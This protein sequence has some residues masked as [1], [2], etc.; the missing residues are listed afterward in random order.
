[1]HIV[2]NWMEEGIEQGRRQGF[3]LGINRGIEREKKLIVHLIKKKLGT[4]DAE[5][6]TQIISLNL[7]VVERLAE[8]TFD[9][10]TVED[11]RN[12]LDNL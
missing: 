3:E 8:A 7:N 2:T 12:W 1:M 11:L 4:I 5:L 6:E 9:F 10:S